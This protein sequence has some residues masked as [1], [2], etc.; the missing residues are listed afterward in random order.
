[1]RFWEFQGNDST[2]K[3]LRWLM[4]EAGFQGKWGKVIAE[5]DGTFGTIFTLDQGRTSVPRYVVAKVPK[6]NRDEKS[7]K[8]RNKILRF[9]HEINETLQIHISSAHC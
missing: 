2:G 5:F 7:E 6:I 4:V 8:L 1:M 3:P 9:L